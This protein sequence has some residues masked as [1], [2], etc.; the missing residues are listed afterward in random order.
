MISHWVAESGIHGKPPRNQVRVHSMRTQAPASL[1]RDPPPNVLEGPLGLGAPARDHIADA[2]GSADTRR[3][4][5]ISL[6]PNEG[7]EDG[8][9]PESGRPISR[10]AL[11]CSFCGKL[12]GDVETMVSGPT[13][14]VAI[15]NEC[16]AVVTEI[17]REERGGPTRAA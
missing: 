7:F 17:M 12:Y 2:E 3:V 13:P 8:P 14:S 15:C 9:E 6:M 4:T 16:V 10:D 5:S 1:R 11:R